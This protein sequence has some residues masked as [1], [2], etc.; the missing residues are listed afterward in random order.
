MRSALLLLVC[1]ASKSAE[2]KPAEVSTPDWLLYALAIG[3][4]AAG[5]HWFRSLSVA[6]HTQ[7]LQQQEAALKAKSSTSTLTS[8]NSPISTM[9]ADPNKSWTLAELREYNGTD[10]SKP[11]LL[12]CGGRVFDVS[13]SRGFYGPGAAYGVFAGRDASRGLARMEIEYKGA[14]I[15]DLS[16][17][18][19]VTLQ[20]WTDKFESKYP[21]VGRIVDST[22]PNSGSASTSTQ[23]ANGQTANPLTSAAPGV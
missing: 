22:E 21:I 11:L 4:V 16:G 10:P 17:S 15:S 9:A 20:E 23:G 5:F 2:S 19:Q 6:P 14:D 18:Q 1:V 7:R 12:G 13:S 3:A 8:P